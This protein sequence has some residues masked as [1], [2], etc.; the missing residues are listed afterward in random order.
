MHSNWK[1]I[2][3][4]LHEN[5]LCNGHGSEEIF[6][7]PK[8][9]QNVDA[10]VPSEDV[11]VSAPPSCIVPGSKEG[12]SSQVSGSNRVSRLAAMYKGMKCNV[13][14]YRYFFCLSNNLFFD[15]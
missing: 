12:G 6:P 10:N 15:R 5:G 3:F 11:M 13:L 2:S 8:L 14:Q 7:L 1:T 4:Q 9:H